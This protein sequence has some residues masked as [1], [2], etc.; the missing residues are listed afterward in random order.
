MFLTCSISS[1]TAAADAGAASASAA[2]VLE[3][4]ERVRLRVFRIDQSRKRVTE[5]WIS[6]AIGILLRTASIARACSVEWMREECNGVCVIYCTR[7]NIDVQKFVGC[8][9]QDATDFGP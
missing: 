4:I 7:Y 2:A 1:K 9:I 8:K 5:G 3:E 6:L